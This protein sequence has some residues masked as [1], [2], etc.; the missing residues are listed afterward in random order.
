MVS[1]TKNNHT[2]KRK[3]SKKH[4]KHSKKQSKH[5]KKQSKSRKHTR[6]RRGGM[7]TVAGIIKKALPSVI[8]FETL[9]ATKKHRSKK[10]RGGTI[11]RRMSKKKSKKSKK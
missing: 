7:G 8:L 3:D 6:S 2:R 10:Q 9:R 5:S 4:S 11:K 1:H